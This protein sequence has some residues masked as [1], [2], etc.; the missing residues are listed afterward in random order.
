MRLL[1]EEPA[2]DGYLSPHTE[3]LGFSALPRVCAG[4]V[5]YRPSPGARLT[6]ARFSVT[7][8]EGPG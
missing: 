3:L 2:R 5:D 7:T 6:D 1:R 4:C 8:D